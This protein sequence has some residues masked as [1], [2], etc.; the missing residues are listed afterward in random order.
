MGI[1]HQNPR[2]DLFSFSILSFARKQQ[3][4]KSREASVARMN[5]LQRGHAALLSFLGLQFLIALASTAPSALRLQLGPMSNS[6]CETMQRVPITSRFAAVNWKIDLNFDAL[7]CSIWTLALVFTPVYS[8]IGQPI[9]CFSKGLDF[10][11]LP[12]SSNISWHN[13]I[14]MK[15]S[16]GIV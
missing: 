8:K 4:K 5:N 11:R 6:N 7:Y 15:S 9:S 10:L 2:S 16:G 1:S 12:N 3:L 13:T 14:E